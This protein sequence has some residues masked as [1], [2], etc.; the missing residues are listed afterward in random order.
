M[1]MNVFGIVACGLVAIVGTASMLQAEPPSDKA[2]QKMNDHPSKDHPKKA[3]GGAAIGAKAPEFSLTDTAGKTVALAE[4]LKEGKIV[5]LEWFN[6]DCPVVKKH[7]EAATT[8]VDLA[9]KYKDK[10]VWIAINSGGKGKEGAGAER[11]AEA[12]KDWNLAY[13]VLLDESG[14]VGKAYGAKTTPHMFIIAKD[15]TLAF[16]GGIDNKK[17]AKA[18]DYV[19]Y[20]DKALTELVAGSNVSTPEADPYGCSVKY[21]AN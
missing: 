5:V 1:K 14:E 19:N 6:P 4:V 11:N 10:V 17:D 20:V 18:N 21:A 7:H 2:K 15:G 9:A 12:V 8:M 3:A 16:K 13:P